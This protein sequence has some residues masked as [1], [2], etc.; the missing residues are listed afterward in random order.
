MANSLCPGA[1]ADTACV[2]LIT[3]VT[4]SEFVRLRANLYRDV[5][6]LIIIFC[7]F[8][9]IIHHSQFIIFF[10]HSA[11]TPL[12]DR[13][14][15]VIASIAKQ[16]PSICKTLAKA[17][18]NWLRDCHTPLCCVRNDV[19]FIGVFGIIHFRCKALHLYVVLS[20]WFSFLKP[21]RADTA[22]VTLITLVT[23]SEFVRLRANLYRDVFQL[24]INNYFLCFPIH[25]SPF[26]IHN[27]FLP[28]ASTPL[29]DQL[30]LFRLL[31]SNSF[32]IHHL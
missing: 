5:F 3:L 8:Q 29:S 4:S 19:F 32:T 31:T 7:V 28:T 24:T 15:L 17:S 30:T 25:N 18:V 22:C 20:I 11:S 26:I 1:R 9:F 14:P 16:S 27:F 6:Q 12:S 2:T 10:L 21:T 13:L 23:S